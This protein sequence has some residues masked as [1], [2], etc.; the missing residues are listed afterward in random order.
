VARPEG[1][2]CDGHGL[3]EGMNLLQSQPW[4]GA[5]GQSRTAAPGTARMAT[6]PPTLTRR[7]R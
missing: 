1:G 5:G 2:Y 3:C 4:A 6:R 7:Q